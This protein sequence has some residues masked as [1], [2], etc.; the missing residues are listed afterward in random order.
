MDGVA[1]PRTRRAIDRS[2]PLVMM[3][4]NADEM[5]ARDMFSM[6]AFDYVRKPF[7]FEVLDRIVTAPVAVGADRGWSPF[8]INRTA[9]AARALRTE[10]VISASV[11]AFATI[12]A[13]SQV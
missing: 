8:G 7:A 3:I 13:S 5:I 4:A 9:P 10:R 6:G 11:T 12:Q 2:I 1:V